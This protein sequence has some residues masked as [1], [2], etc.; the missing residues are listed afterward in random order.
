MTLLNECIELLHFP[1]TLGTVIAVT[2]ALLNRYSILAI[3]IQLTAD[4]IALT[5]SASCLN[6]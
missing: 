6:L 4:A 2:E 5:R 3:S 1:L